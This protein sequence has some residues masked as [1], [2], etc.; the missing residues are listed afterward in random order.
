MAGD[1]YAYLNA[2]RDYGVLDPNHTLGPVR[3][4]P[5]DNT[6]PSAHAQVLAELATINATKRADYTISGPYDNFLWVSQQVGIPVEQV[7]DVFIE[8]KRFRLKALLATGKTP[9]HESIR[10]TRVDLANYQ[11][12]KVAMY[13]AGLLT[14]EADSDG[15]QSVG[16]LGRVV[17]GS[18][19]CERGGC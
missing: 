4:P 14:R 13:D 5:E 15:G 9:N 3:L 1:R 2:K 17:P 16:D 6:P 8:T 12:I 7:L 10:D 19:C 11:V 18:G